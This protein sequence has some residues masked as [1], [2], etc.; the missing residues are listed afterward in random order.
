MSI[1]K[2]ERLSIEFIADSADSLDYIEKTSITDKTKINKI[3]F[4]GN[5]II[6]F[7]NF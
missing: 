2:S 6:F 4:F 7:V 3:I 5:K 1:G